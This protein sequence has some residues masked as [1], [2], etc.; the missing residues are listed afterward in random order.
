MATATV[1]GTS[2]GSLVEAV[3]HAKPGDTIT[4]SGVHTDQQLVITSKLK[5]LVVVGASG[6]SISSTKG[7][8]VQCSAKGVKISGL[9][10]STKDGEACVLVPREG[11]L[12]LVSCEVRCT[13]ADGVQVHGECVLESCKVLECGTYGVAAIAGGLVRTKATTVAFSAKTGALSRGKG[14]RVVLDA[15]TIVEKNKMHG[16]G[17]DQGV[18][19]FICEQ[20]STIY[21]QPRLGLISS[22][23]VLQVAR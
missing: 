5:D 10:L 16:V 7:P 6:A 13:A 17:A 3:V 9:A 2:Y 20:F 23:L 21:P 22:R 12:T 1:G 14:S 18:F 8:A 4:I 11:S 15:G 19:L